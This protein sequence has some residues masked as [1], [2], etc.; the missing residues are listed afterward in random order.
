MCLDPMLNAHTTDLDVSD[1]G[2]QVFP[3][4]EISRCLVS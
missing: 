2:P 1:L 4:Q 3:R